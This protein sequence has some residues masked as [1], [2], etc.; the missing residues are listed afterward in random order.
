MSRYADFTARNQFSL[1]LEERSFWFQRKTLYEVKPGLM[2]HFILKFPT[3]TAFTDSDFWETPRGFISFI[4]LSNFC[5]LSF[6]FEFIL[7]DFDSQVVDCI[8]Y[9]NNGNNP[10]Y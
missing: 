5:F 6:L 8:D 4:F 2:K 3:L 7:L 9:F 10:R 1:E